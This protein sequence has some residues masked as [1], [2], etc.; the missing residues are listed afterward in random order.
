MTIKNPA[1]HICVTRSGQESFISQEIS[2]S[3][4]CQ[5]TQLAPGVVELS[6]VEREFL[7]KYPLF[8]ACQILP[9]AHS[10]CG[11]S[12]NSIAESICAV[13][14]ERCAELDQGWMLHIYE[15]KSAESGEIYGRARLIETQLT[16]SLK[17]R[18]RSLIRSL[19]S[20]R[21]KSSH[22]VQV[23]VV[24]KS[25]NFISITSPDEQRA[26]GSNISPHAAGFIS[27]ADDPKPPSR[28]FKKLLEAIERFDLHPQRGESCVDLGASP[29]G[30]SSVM[31]DLGLK[32]TGVDRSPLDDRLMQDRRCSFVQ[33]NAHSWTPE[34]SV[35]W[36]ICDVITTPQRTYE[37][38]QKWLCQKL[39]KSFCVTVKFQGAPEFEQLYAIRNLLKAHT[40]SF[41]GK[42][43]THNKNE[44]TVVGFSL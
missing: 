33:G 44:L 6:G 14:I 29:G 34:V 11:D 12:I 18:R 13:L 27:I 31:L 2:R 24:G 36:L 26:L 32:V 25:L 39:C 30:W 15:P 20:T 16:Q 17:R 5:C 40:S 35:D 7:Q 1:R 19:R 3:T 23:L 4:E 9:N 28:A 42:Q 10:L 38:L 41:D 22:L 43:L 8:F 21:D 37:I